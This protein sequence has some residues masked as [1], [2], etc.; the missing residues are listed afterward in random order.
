M[1]ASHSDPRGHDVVMV[2]G[3]A[4]GIGAA[5]VRL[6]ASHGYTLVVLDIQDEAGAAVAEEVKGRYLRHD[7]TKVEDWQ[8]NLAAAVERHGDVHGLVNAAGIMTKYAFTEPDAD[9]FAQVLAVN[10]LGAALGTQI[11]GAHMRDNGHGSIV[12][13]A[14]AA[15]MPPSRSPDIAY[16]SSKWGVRGVSR[17]AAVALAPGGVRVNTVLPGVTDTPMV[18]P[19]QDE[20]LPDRIARIADAIPMR[21]LAQPLDIARAVHFFISDL[22]DYCT[23]S[24]LLVDGGLGA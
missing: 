7:V 4:S 1:N 5:V 11:L 13:I 19:V 8:A 16:V 24:E 18:R 15:G 23:G 20:P 2:T 6:L 21:R 9:R 10:Q 14:S 3:G 12:N 17:T 22:S